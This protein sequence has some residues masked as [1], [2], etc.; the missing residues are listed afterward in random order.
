MRNTKANIKR[1]AIC[2][3]NETKTEKDVP[4]SVLHQVRVAC[5][6]IP[7]EAIT[8]PEGFHP[9][10]YWQKAWKLSKPTAYQYLHAA[11]RHKILETRRF[12]AIKTG[13]RPAFYWRAIR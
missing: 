10:S 11:V 2:A 6:I 4:S 9:A 12:P 1:R 8:P 3:I 5:G 7:P 13:G